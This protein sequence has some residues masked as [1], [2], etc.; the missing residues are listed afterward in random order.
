VDTEVTASVLE[1]KGE[2][3]VQQPSVVHDTFV[4]ERHFPKP[5]EK[6]FAAISEPAKRRR[7]FAEGTAHDV[8]EFQSDF[9]VGGAEVLR[10]RFKL[11]APSPVAGAV[12][13]NEGRFEDIVPNRRIVTASAMSLGDKRISASLMTLELLANENGTD[14]ICT[15]QGSFFEGSDG[16]KIRE[17]GWRALLD[18]LV[19]ELSE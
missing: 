15:H 7:W 10:Y 5:P 6:V 1:R 11:T 8:E 12:L 9:R 19:K 18:R 13:T 2:T 17:E 16:P 14:L 4:I 3:Q